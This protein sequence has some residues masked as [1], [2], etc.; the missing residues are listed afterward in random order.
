MKQNRNN[1]LESLQKKGA[2]TLL[3]DFGS[4]IFF[5]WCTSGL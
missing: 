2:V 5:L 3:D 1:I 4:R